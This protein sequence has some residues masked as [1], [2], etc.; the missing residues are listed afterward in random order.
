VPAL[1]PGGIKTK[2]I[3]GWSYGCPVLGNACALEGLQLSEYPLSVP[4]EAWDSYIL[5]PEEHAEHWALAARQGNK[6]VRETLSRE[7]Y[8][9]TWQQIVSPKT[10]RVGATAVQPA[11]QPL[12]AAQTI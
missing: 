7:G 5:H 12:A 2:V 11:L 3:E 4:E 6:F 8:A 10:V 9:L 1:L